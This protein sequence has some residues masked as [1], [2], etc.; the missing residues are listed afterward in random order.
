MFTIG[1]AL[2]GLGIPSPVAA[3]LAIVTAGMVLY[4][5]GCWLSAALQ[6]GGVLAFIIAGVAAFPLTLDRLPQVNL[7]VVVV[8]VVGVEVLVFV[9]I[10]AAARALVRGAAVWAR[11]RYARRR[12][13]QFEQTAV[14]DVAGPFT[15]L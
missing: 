6:V 4:G 7:V 3:W 5:A 10:R 11:R 12:G 1:T 13:W 2:D 8:V 15:A 14:V 9:G